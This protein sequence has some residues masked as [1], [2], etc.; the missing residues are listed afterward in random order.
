MSDLMGDGRKSRKALP[1]SRVI[2][3]MS[4]CNFFYAFALFLSMWPT[5]S[6][7]ENVWGNVGTQ[8]FCTC[9][10]FFV[11]FDLMGTMLWSLT[12]AVFYL[13]V[14]RYNWKDQQLEKLE[15]WLHGG[16]WMI[17][18]GLAIAPIPLKMYNH[19]GPACWI[20]SLPYGCLDSLTYGTDANCVCGDNAWIFQLIVFC[21]SMWLCIFVVLVIL[22]MVYCVVRKLEDQSLPYASTLSLRPSRN[23]SLSILARVQQVDQSTAISVE[24]ENVV[25]KQK[26]S[27]AVAMQGMF[28][29]IALIILYTMM[30]AYKIINGPPVLLSAV[31]YVAYLT[32]PL[33]G[34]LKFL[35]LATSQMR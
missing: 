4:I 32:L 5:P 7:E 21:L 31:G 22:V 25:V 23:N 35:V 1:I 17:A 2:L 33:Q 14:V 18:L 20:E 26:K 8:G 24:M 15:K 34:F 3:S 19:S 27:K 12:L 10:G 29:M 9:Q 30:T 16:I 6:Q 28:Y 11:Q 13:L